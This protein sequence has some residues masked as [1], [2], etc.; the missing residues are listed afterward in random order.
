MK[1]STL[2]R[3]TARSM[4]HEFERLTAELAS[5][6]TKGAAREEIVREFL[7]CYLPQRF[8]VEGGQATDRFGNT[9][10]Q[11]DAL[12]LDLEDTPVL[13]SAPGAKVFLCES[14]RG[15]IEVKSQLTK[16]GLLEDAR[17]IRRLKRLRRALNDPIHSVVQGEQQLVWP[18][19]PIIGGLFA[20]SSAQ[21]MTTLGTELREWNDK[22]PPEERVDFLAVL[23]EAILT[24]GGEDMSPYQADAHEGTTSI[25]W[26]VTPAFALLLVCGYILKRLMGFQLYSGRLPVVDLPSYLS[27][28]IL[29]LAVRD[30]RSDA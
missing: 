17:K 22:V 20:Y 15:A 1:L 25:E 29:D 26:P 12:I 3:S 10:G 11:M 5:P 21:S 16:T 24:F 8:Q 18:C 13:Y 9:S 28:A 2:L 19:P 7:R 23:G 4:Q 27:T 30:D 6:G 14:V